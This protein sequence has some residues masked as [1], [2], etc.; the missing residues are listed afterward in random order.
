MNQFLSHEKIIEINQQINLEQEQIYL[1]KNQIKKLEKSI[2]DKK[3]L[4]LKNCL[5]EKIID[6]TFQDEHTQYYCK[7]CGIEL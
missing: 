6:R 7:V 1:L 3:N 4:L 5:H 2:E